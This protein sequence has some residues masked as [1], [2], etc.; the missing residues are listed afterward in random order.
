M[1]RRVAT[2]PHQLLGRDVEWDTIVLLEGLKIE[3][4]GPPPPARLDLAGFSPREQGNDRIPGRCRAQLPE[5]PTT[6]N[7]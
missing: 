3:D 1:A 6:A 5:I 2:L 7:A 4:D